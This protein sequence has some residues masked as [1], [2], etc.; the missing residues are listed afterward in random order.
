MTELCPNVVMIELE[1]P[2]FIEPMMKYKSEGDTI[3]YLGNSPTN[4]KSIFYFETKNL[5]LF[6]FPYTD[7]KGN[8][9]KNILRPILLQEKLNK[10]LEFCDIYTQIKIDE[11]KCTDKSYLLTPEN[12]K[13]AKKLIK[14]MNEFQD[15]EY[16]KFQRENSNNIETWVSQLFSDVKNPCRIV[17]FY[18]IDKTKKTFKVST[19]V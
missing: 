17:T 10:F 19:N 6:Y 4:K 11:K 15:N 12:E 13:F 8:L 16:Q 14:K 9:I 2:F 5:S 1:F 3:I 18:L 7:H